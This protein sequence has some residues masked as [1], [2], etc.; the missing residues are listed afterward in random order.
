[1]AK[2]IAERVWLHRRQACGDRLHS[3]DFGEPLLA[4]IGV[5]SLAIPLLACVGFGFVLMAIPGGWLVG[6][7]LVCGGCTGLVYNILWAVKA[8]EAEIRERDAMLEA[9]AREAA[10][11]AAEP[12]RPGFQRV[13]VE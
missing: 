3:M 2:W 8:R 7:F 12:P 11:P 9:Y 10:G 4:A 1:M 13:D 5:R 6:L